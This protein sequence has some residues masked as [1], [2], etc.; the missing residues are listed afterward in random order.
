MTVQLNHTIIH[1][2][3]KDASAA[4]YTDVLGLPPAGTFGPFRVVA[5]DNEVSLD[6]LDDSDEIH[7]QH[8]CFLVSEA[9]FDQ[10]LARVQERELPYWADPAQQRPQSIN[11]NDGGRGVYWLDPD[12]HIL[13]IITRPYGSGR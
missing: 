6:L 4:F 5:V 9:E 12:G 1:V 2:R 11:R 8:Y 3:D 10:I 7:S 13:E